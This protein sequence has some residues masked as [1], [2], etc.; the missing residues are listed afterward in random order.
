MADHLIE[1]APNAP[2]EKQINPLLKFALELGPLVVFFFANSRG[3]WLAGK[4][5][6]L[7]E[8][9]GPLFIATA[10][11]MVAT[12]A[13]L[14]V[15]WALTRTLPIM[16]L[17]SGLFV[18]V[19]GGLT[20]WLQNET[21]IKMKPTIVNALFA[22]ILLGGLLFGRSLLGYVFNQAFKLD[23]D[24]WR[25]LTLRWGVFFL[26]MAVVNE[27]VWRN[28]S[29]DFWAGFKVWATMPITMIFMLCQIPLLQRHATEP[30]VK[31]YVKPKK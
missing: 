24:G 31:E 14:S 23:D 17:V 8:L 21:F 12:I 28:F 29:T 6:A 1:G 5:P 18:V 13:A 30:L 15:S 16:P 20:L 11:F 7:A 26:V 19:F 3:E 10:L 27:L 4:F 22:T 2:E 9:G 25:K